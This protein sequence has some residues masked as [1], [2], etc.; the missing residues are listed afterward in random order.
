MDRDELCLVGGPRVE[1]D[2]TVAS[3]GDRASHGGESLGTFGM[4]V[5]R[6]VLAEAPV[7]DD[8]N[9]AGGAH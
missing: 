6:T 3:L 8:R 1:R 5:Q 2:Q 9:A 7:F 4:I